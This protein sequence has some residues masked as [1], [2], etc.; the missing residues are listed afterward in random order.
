L[1]NLPEPDGELVDLAELR[2]AQE[3][4]DAL[5]LADFREELA[6]LTAPQGEPEEVGDSDDGDRDE[7]DNEEEGGRRQR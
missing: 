1:D 5:A 2:A 7:D 3:E 6:E 4:T